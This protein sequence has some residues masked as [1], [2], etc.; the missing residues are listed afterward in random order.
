VTEPE[1]RQALQD[2][3]LDVLEKMFFATPLEEPDESG[4]PADGIAVELAFEGEPS[5][6]LF[7]SMST[8]AAGR[9]AADFLGLDESEVSTAQTTD[10]VC[11]LANMICGSVLSRVESTVRF[12][13]ASPR[14]LPAVRELPACLISTPYCVHLIGGTLAVQ[15]DTGIATCHLSVPSAY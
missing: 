12:R 3:V 4:S 9:I 13:L 6:T 14:V 11:E 8:P 2:A 15:L 1:I 10:V 7:L 5:G